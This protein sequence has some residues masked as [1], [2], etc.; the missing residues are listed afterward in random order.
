MP[1]GAD[2]IALLALV[3]AIGRTGDL[4]DRIGSVTPL[5][6]ASWPTNSANGG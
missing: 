3:F 2:W 4:L 1:L 5:P 6:L